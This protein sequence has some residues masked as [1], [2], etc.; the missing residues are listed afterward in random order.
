MTTLTQK[1]HELAVAL[2]AGRV[3]PVEVARLLEGGKPMVRIEGQFAPGTKV[4]LFRVANPTQRGES[5]EKVATEKVDKYGVVEFTDDIDVAAYYSAIGEDMDGTQRT[6]RATGKVPPEA[7]PSRATPLQED[8]VPEPESKQERDE[9]KARA[10][11][12]AEEAATDPEP[13]TKEWDRW[14]DKRV[15]AQAKADAL[16][17]APDKAHAGTEQINPPAKKPRKDSDEPATEDDGGVIHAPQPLSVDALDD[18]VAEAKALAPD[19]KDPT[20]D[21]DALAGDPPVEADEKK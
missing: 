19:A 14:N 1:N 5:G 11:A 4:D 16:E 8:P 12:D 3:S 10:E 13:G 20:Q 21:L 17:A 6:I 15:K 9:I 18:R 7:A 2:R